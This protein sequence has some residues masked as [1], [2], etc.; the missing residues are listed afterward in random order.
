MNH[1]CPHIGPAISR[2]HRHVS[3]KSRARDK[4]GRKLVRKGNS[5]V[6]AGTDPHANDGYC[7][8]AVVVIRDR[9]I[10]VRVRL[11]GRYEPIDG[12]YRWYGRIGPNATL[13]EAV[14]AEGRVYARIRT[15]YRECDA[16]I[17][18]VDLWGRFR[19]T[20]RSTPPYPVPT[21]LG[22]IER[23]KEIQQ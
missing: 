19:I 15:P 7:V 5:V 12:V 8:S 23:T 14:G 4:R 16:V 20:G 17:G 6:T 10:P 21:H 3:S 9:E 18:E 1:P 22:E 2:W 11:S 13:T